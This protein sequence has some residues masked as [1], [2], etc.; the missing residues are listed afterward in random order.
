MLTYIKKFYSVSIY[1]MFTAF[2]L[3]S[4]D[5]DK[6]V[7]EGDIAYLGGEIINPS[8]KTVVL[9]KGKTP[10][11]TLSLDKDNR[12]IYKFTFLEP[13]LYTFHHGTDIQM[14]LLEPNDSIMFRLNTID[15]DES[16]VYTGD[17]AKKNNF[18]IEMFLESEKEDPKVLRFCQN[19]ANVFEK[20]IDSLRESKIEKLNEFNMKYAPS[21][22]FMEVAKANIDYSYYASKEVY[23]FVYYSYSQIKNLNSLPED[24]YSYRK[25]VD[26]NNDVLKDYFPYYQFLNNH[27][28]NLAVSEHIKKSHDSVFNP[29]TASYNLVKMKLIDSLVT[30][31]CIKNNLLTDT[32]FRFFSYANNIEQNDTILSTYLQLSTDEIKKEQSIGYTNTLKK[33]APGNVIPSIKVIDAKNNTHTLRDIIEKPTIIY[34]WSYTIKMH[35]KESHQKIAE[36]QKK[37]PEI[38][39]I[40]ININNGDPNFWISSLTQYHFPLVNEYRFEDPDIAKETLALYPINKVILTNKKGIIEK[41]N[42]NMFSI[43]FEEDLLGLINR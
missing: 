35:F 23:P 5:K 41:S 29:K 6:K 10:L 27:F 2:L 26:Y 24:F 13:G 31:E 32:A 42:A 3:L 19:S 38:D 8:N 16:L 28:R 21:N 7:D 4:C 20:H 14:V 39:V 11:D 30:N 22:L 1:F 9:Y 40:S 25:D 33:L 34:F 36:L 37:Y 15:F 43:N 12:F 18:L 17:G